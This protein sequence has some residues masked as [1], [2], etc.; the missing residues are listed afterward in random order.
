MSNK[1]FLFNKDS[2]AKPFKKLY[3]LPNK[4]YKK[5]SIIYRLIFMA[6]LVY[7]VFI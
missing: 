3:F 7:Y 4:V 1:T 2:W 6:F 5:I